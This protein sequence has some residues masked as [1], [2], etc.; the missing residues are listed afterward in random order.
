MSRPPLAGVLCPVATPFD[1]ATGD[2]APGALRSNVT[3]LLAD[4]RSRLEQEVADLLAKGR[5][6][7]AALEAY[8]AARSG[9]TAR[10]VRTNRETPPDF[11]IIKVE[12]LV[13]DLEVAIGVIATPAAVAQ[14]VCDRLVAV[15][16]SSI[17][18]FAPSVLVVPAPVTIRQADMYIGRQILAF[19]RDDEPDLGDRLADLRDDDIHQRC[20]WTSSRIAARIR[21]SSG[22]SCSSSCGENGIGTSG[23]V[24]RRI[25]SSR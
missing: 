16:V 2:V 24:S 7:P 9:P 20:R 10:V 1:A 11:I 4:G 25:G 3:R 8:Q 21:S 18:N 22:T 5:D 6:A 14:D 15:G 19:R 13:G 23:V 12:E 17:L